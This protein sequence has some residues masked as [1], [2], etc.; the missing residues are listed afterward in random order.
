LPGASIFTIAATGF[1][2]RIELIQVPDT[3]PPPQSNTSSFLRFVNLA[4]DAPPLDLAL[5]NGQTI[6]QNIA[7]KDISLYRRLTP[8]AHTLTFSVSAS[9]LRILPFQPI[10]L[11]PAT[12]YTVYTIGFSND[13]AQR[14]V[15]VLPDGLIYSDIV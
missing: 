2:G 9:G 6:L 10:E 7:Y 12:L 5:E 14:R 13:S 1:P 8:G 15:V 3:L 11:E 4:S